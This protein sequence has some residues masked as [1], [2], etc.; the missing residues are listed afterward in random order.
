ML[1]KDNDGDWGLCYAAWLGMS[2]GRPGK[3]GTRYDRPV[4][5]IKGKPG[6]CKLI[7]KNLR[8]VLC[9]RAIH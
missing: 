6:Y 9:P 5:G 8:F 2:T 4:P 3:P 1:I 7:F